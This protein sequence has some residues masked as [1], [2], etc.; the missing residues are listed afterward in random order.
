MIF[1]HDEKIFFVR[2]FFWDQVCIS[3]NPRNHLEHLPCPHDDLESV[4]GATR[5]KL[6][7]FCF[8]FHQTSLFRNQLRD[9]LVQRPGM[10]PEYGAVESWCGVHLERMLQISSCFRGDPKGFV[11][12]GY[13][14]K[15]Y[16]DI[17]R[18]TPF[19]CC[20]SENY[21]SEPSKSVKVCWA[22]R[23]VFSDILMS[24]ATCLPL[25]LAVYV[26]MKHMR[27]HPWWLYPSIWLA[28][29]AETVFS[30]LYVTYTRGAP[31]KVVTLG[32][33]KKMLSWV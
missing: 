16:Q 30:S 8:I 32:G 13:N 11:I 9:P 25:L 15:K 1:L 33:L 23:N 3:S 26:E 27:V 20:E 12:S 5:K 19:R 7:F 2:I 24:C 14:I 6:D 4:C 18:D 31:K 21:Q 29:L 28:K 17:S 10:N 22:V